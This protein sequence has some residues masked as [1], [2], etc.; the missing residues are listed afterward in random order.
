MNI[1]IVGH[2]I[3]GSRREVIAEVNGESRVFEVDLRMR[4][5]ELASAVEL[6]VRAEA[7]ERSGQDMT[8]D[9]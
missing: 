7:A 8:N 1:K 3:N 6:C 5:E 4:D 9:T 2:R